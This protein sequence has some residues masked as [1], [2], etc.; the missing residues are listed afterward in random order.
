MKSISVPAGY[1]VS[2]QQFSWREDDSAK[3]LWLVFAAGVI[4][5]LLAVAMVFDSVWAAVMVFLA[6]PLCLGGVAATFWLTGTSFTREAV[7]GVIL[8]VG[9]SV[10]QAILLVDAALVKRRTGRLT[11]EDILHAASDRAGMI[12]LVTLTTLGSLIPLAVGTD[13]NSLFGSIALAIAGGTVAGTLGAMLIVPA[14]LEGRR[15][16]VPAPVEPLPAA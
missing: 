5:V 13:A 15:V 12:M 8:V 14:F 2:D 4:L 9:H 1:S 11:M 7:V 16:K 3:G 6:L 10:N